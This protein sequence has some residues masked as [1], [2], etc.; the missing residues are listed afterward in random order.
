MGFT[1]TARRHISDEWF[2]ESKEIERCA[3]ENGR[4]A[5]RMG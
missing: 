2:N 3:K 1:N 5:V 4:Q